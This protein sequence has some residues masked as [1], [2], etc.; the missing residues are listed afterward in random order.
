MFHVNLQG[1]KG[2]EENGGGLEVGYTQKVLVNF[3]RWL[4]I[5]KDSFFFGNFFDPDPRGCMIDPKWTTAHIF[6]KLGE[7]NHQLKTHKNY[8]LKSNIAT[9]NSHV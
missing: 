4:A 5:L 3:G 6:F 9:Q 8:T 7:K 1:C 2:R